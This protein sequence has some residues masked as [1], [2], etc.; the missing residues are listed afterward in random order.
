[1]SEMNEHHAIVHNRIF[2]EIREE[3]RRQTEKFGPMDN[4]PS[5]W[6]VILGEE[7]GEVCRAIL[8]ARAL[9]NTGSQTNYREELIQV[10]AVAVAAIAN[11]DMQGPI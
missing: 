1:M 8:D 3:R 6:A 5:T 7:V 11:L 10:A 2:Q 9:L 4:T